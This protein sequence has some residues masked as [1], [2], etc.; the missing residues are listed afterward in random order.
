VHLF[1]AEL[2]KL[3]TPEPKTRRTVRASGMTIGLRN[4]RRELYIPCTM[5]SNNSEWE[6]GWFYLRNDGADLPAYSGKVL[7]DKADSWHHG[8]SPPSHQTRL[9]SL[10]DTLKDLAD[11]GLTAGC[12]LANLHHRGIVPLMERPLRIFEMHEDV[13]PVTL[14]QSQ[15]LPGLFSREYAATRARRA[16]DL[17][18]GRNDDATLWAFTMLPVG[19]LVSGLPLPLVL[20]V[21]EALSCLE[22]LPVP[23]QIRVVNTARSDPPTPRSRAHARSAAAGAGAGGAQEGAKPPAARAPGTK[24]QGV[25]AARAAGALLSRD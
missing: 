21:R 1:H 10:L 25:P 6:R 3:T 15:L 2:H 22:I 5:T 23:L 4:T 8:V 7:K 13:D 19:P 17:R 18:T 24:E 14:A 20:P 12:V 16:I 9:D 11:S